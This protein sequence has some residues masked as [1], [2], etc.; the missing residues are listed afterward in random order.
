VDFDTARDI[1]HLD[2]P[3]NPTDITQRRTENYQPNPNGYKMN[4]NSTNYT[5][6]DDGLILHEGS[7][8][9]DQ[10]YERVFALGTGTTAFATAPSS[11]AVAIGRNTSA[12]ARGLGA[13]AI[14]HNSSA[15]ASAFGEGA[16][17]IIV[18]GNATAHQGAKAYT[19][20]EL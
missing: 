10:P 6:T 4:I 9:A 20:N 3:Q 14:S 5:M 7:A 13:R 11:E 15:H 2:Q 8:T 18:N 17:A 12:E 16:I 19:V 1:P